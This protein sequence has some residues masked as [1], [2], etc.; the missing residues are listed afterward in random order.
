[1]TAEEAL[2][3]VGKVNER[4]RELEEKRH[5]AASC[6]ITEAL[7][8][9]QQEIAGAA[10]RKEWLFRSIA[11]ARRVASQLCAAMAGADLRTPGRGCEP[12]HDE[13]QN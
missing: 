8:Q 3:E 9:L 13:T 1:M 11:C 10:A 12:T 4:L 2:A 6:P 7:P 5:Q